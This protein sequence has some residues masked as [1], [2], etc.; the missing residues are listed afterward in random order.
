MDKTPAKLNNQL[1][2]RINVSLN[3]DKS[4]ML[5]KVQSWASDAGLVQRHSN[6]N[7]KKKKRRTYSC[8]ECENRDDKEGFKAKR[9]N[10]YCAPKCIPLWKA[11]H[12]CAGAM[13]I[14]SVSFQFFRMSPRRGQYTLRR[15]AGTRVGF[16]LCSTGGC[17]S[18]GSRCSHDLSIKASLILNL[19]LAWQ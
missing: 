5:W 6:E 18:R 3:P 13:L 15:S 4:N 2:Y 11:C 12:P 16:A 8:F 19:P 17:N 10:K 1:C 14:F 7:G 9:S